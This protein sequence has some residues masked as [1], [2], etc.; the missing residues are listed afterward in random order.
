MACAFILTMAACGGDSDDDPKTAS[1]KAPESST[2]APADA[3]DFCTQFTDV[4][5]TLSL[6]DISLATD[7]AKFPEA[8]KQLAAVDPPEEIAMPWRTTTEFYGH[9][10]GMFQGVDFSD[11]AAVGAVL[12]KKLGPDTE[13]RAK[14]AEQAIATIQTYTDANCE[15]PKDA[16]PA[17]M[18]DAC[19]L[20]E[21]KDLAKVFPTGLP[22]PESQTYGPDSIECIWK[23][24]D[25]E[26]SIMVVPIKD[27][28][29][30]FLDKS[31]PMPAGEIDGLEGGDTYKGVLGFGRFNTKG[32]SVS[33]TTD[34]LGGF[35][36]VRHPGSD[37]RPAQVGTATTLAKVV[38]AKL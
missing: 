30:E 25:A 4:R 1:S 34:T 19:T 9:I 29:R 18:T 27:F 33:F 8:A 32:H 2:S 5:G 35:V 12:D 31:T 38:V 17:A 6:I 23:T 16:Q 21:P 22:T 15:T 37:S 28:K 14:K 7:W 13:Q 3:A 11:R 36:S 10:A 20:L 26:A 24:E